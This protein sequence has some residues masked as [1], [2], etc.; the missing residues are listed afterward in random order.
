MDKRYA[1]ISKEAFFVKSYYSLYGIGMFF[2]DMPYLSFLSLQGIFQSDTRFDTKNENIVKD[3]I[4]ILFVHGFSGSSANWRYFRQKMEKKGFKNIYSIDLGS[5][6]LSIE[7]YAEKL[8]RKVDEILVKTG[9]QKVQIV[10]HSMGGV[11]SLEYMAKNKNSLKVDRLVT[12]ASP[13]RGT[14]VGYISYFAK[15]ARQMIP[16]SKYMQRFAAKIEGLDNERL[17]FGSMAD[18]IIRPTNHCYAKDFDKK[19]NREVVSPCGHTQYLFSNTVIEDVA[20]F[21]KG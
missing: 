9:S 6:N 2:A 17:H 3:Q 11:V 14:Y 12:L 20:D 7:A 1:K 15:P 13:L 21:L 10:A 18:P 8:E 19:H 5:P 16:G 4:P